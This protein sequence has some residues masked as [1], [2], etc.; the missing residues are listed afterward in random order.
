MSQINDTTRFLQRGFQLTL[1]KSMRPWVI[2]PMIFNIVLFSLLY[3]L[4]IHYI[5]SW[6]SELANGWQLSGFF[7]FLN[8]AIPYLIGALKLLLWVLLFVVFASV[9]TLAVQLVAS[10]FL[11][12][13]AEKVNHE[14]SP[15][16]LPEESLLATTKRTLLRETAKLWAWLWRAVLVLFVVLI[17]YLIPG[18]NML[19][20]VIWFLF[21]GWMMALQYIDYG[22]DCRQT[23]LKHLNQ[24]M[25]GKRWLVLG[26]GCIMLGLTMLPLI[27][28]FI[29]PVGVVTGTLI[30][31]ERLSPDRLLLTA[32][33]K[34]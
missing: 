25:H 23:S 31:N 10:P 2:V 11:G 32:D 13:L 29:M 34:L 15:Q 28:L 19:A 20:P 8:S 9:F 1:K 18:L 16:P 14:T 7:S 33:N 30:W 4:G 12:F 17:L 6:F 27:N 26:F 3:W 21:C 5:N 24:A 22:A